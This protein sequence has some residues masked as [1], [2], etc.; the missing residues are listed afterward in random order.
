MIPKTLFLA[1]F[2][3]AG[4][5]ATPEQK[6]KEKDL[7]EGDSETEE[8]ITKPGTPATEPTAGTTGADPE[9]KPAQ[10]VANEPVAAQADARGSAAVVG[11][12]RDVVSAEIAGQVARASAPGAEAHRDRVRGLAHRRGRRLLRLGADR[13]AALDDDR[14]PD[15][16][17]G[18]PRIE[19][20]P[21]ATRRETTARTVSPTPRST[22]S[23]GPIA[24]A[25][26]SMSS[27][28][29]SAKSWLGVMLPG[30]SA[31]TSSTHASWAASATARTVVAGA[32][33]GSA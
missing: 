23:S 12:D 10:E 31:L 3:A 26:R 9:A 25:Q 33:A 24:I 22:T 7:P 19:G 6:D 28:E 5:G 1:L 2:F 8:Q 14:A 32:F 16:D 21:G 18:A 4:I 30:F 27:Y 20:R 11:V 15:R 13:K 17:A 29:V